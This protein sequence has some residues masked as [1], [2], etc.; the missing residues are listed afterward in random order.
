[1]S[2]RKERKIMEQALEMEARVEEQ[3]VLEDHRDEDQGNPLSDESPAEQSPTEDEGE[4]RSPDYIEPDQASLIASNE[5][6]NRS[7]GTFEDDK[8][9]LEAENESREEKIARLS[10]EL[11]ELTGTTSVPTKA[12]NQASGKAGSKKYVLLREMP[13]WGKVP[14]QQL[15]LARVLVSNLVIGQEYTEQEVF[16][17]LN[18]DKASY[19]SLANSRQDVTYLFRYYRGLKKDVKHAGFVARGFL[20]TL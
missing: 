7:T 4:N 5:I 11:A 13:T 10:A 8:A 16:D 2:K 14:Q 15:D 18:K 1:M 12:K 17:V 6:E 9:V 20:K 3:V 19:P